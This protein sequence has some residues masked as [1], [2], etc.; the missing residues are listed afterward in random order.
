MNLFKLLPIVLSALLLGAHFYRAAL[1][2]LV[3]YALLFPGQLLFRR[4][5]AVRLVQVV[6]VLGA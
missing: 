4:V 1:S 2:P 3:V 5:W 6:L